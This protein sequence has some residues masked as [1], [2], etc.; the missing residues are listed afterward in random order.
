MPVRDELEDAVPISGMFVQPIVGYTTDRLKTKFGRRKP[1]IAAGTAL[2]CM[3]VLIGFA[4]NFGYAVG[5]KIDQKAKPRAVALFVLGFWIL[6]IANNMVQARV[7]EVL[8]TCWELIQ[9]SCILIGIENGS[10]KA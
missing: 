2:I 1:F 7:D 10:G 3:A 9:L 4:V 5:N 6:D 8:E